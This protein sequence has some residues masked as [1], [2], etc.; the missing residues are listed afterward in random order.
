MVSAPM[1]AYA[2]GCRAAARSQRGFTM[3]ELLV[4]LLIGLFLLGGL[5]SMVQS[6]RR[7]FASQNQLSQLQD[8]ERV[9]MTMITDVIQ[10]SVYF[11][12]PTNNTAT[13]A[14]IAAGP[15]TAGQALRGTYS[16]AAPGDTITVR[17]ATTNGDGIVNC[18]CQTNA[19]GNI[20]PLMYTNV[21]SVSNGQLR[22]ALNGAAAIALA[23]T[24]PISL[25]NPALN[26]GVVVN[27]LTI[28]YGINA[29]GV[30]QSVTEYVNASAVANWSTVIS[31]RVTL[32]FL[33]PMWS[34]AGQTAG[35]TVPQYLD[36][37]R[38]VGVMNQ[39]GI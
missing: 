10:S 17:Y 22:C 29:A 38:V 6:N 24:V 33:N 13:T 19:S 35:S 3:I 4:A 1:P 8:A 39:T 2:P 7:S 12:D 36:F 14:L 11:P 31:V 15:L 25:T 23:G 34:L 37:Q 20:A 5:M 26:N 27:K 18:L 9:A 16:A 32:E 28:L 30:D 21:F